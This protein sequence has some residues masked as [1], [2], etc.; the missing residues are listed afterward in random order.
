M[1]GKERMLRALNRETPDRLPATVHQWQ[2]YHLEH[3]MDGVDALKAFE[4]TGLDVFPAIALP[5]NEIELNTNMLNTGEVPLT[6]TLML[7]VGTLDGSVAGITETVHLE[8]G[9]SHQVLHLLQTNDLPSG[10]YTVSVYG[11][12]EGKST[13]VWIS[14]FS[15]QHLVFL[16]LVVR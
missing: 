5:G 10:M 12:Y 3:Y 16:P 13:E 15:L 14:S 2:G 11:M 6:A 4:I 7:R 1:T 8:T 9:A